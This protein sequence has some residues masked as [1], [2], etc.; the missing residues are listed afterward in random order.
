MKLRK[1]AE[2]SNGGVKDLN[3]KQMEE[4]LSMLD[5]H[6]AQHGASSLVTHIDKALGAV[7]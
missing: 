4:F 6:V 2:L 7:K 3:E 5:N 1:F